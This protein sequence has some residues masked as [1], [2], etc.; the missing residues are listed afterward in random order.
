MENDSTDYQACLQQYFISCQQYAK[1]E[2]E[3]AILKL[4]PNIT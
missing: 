2:A 4:H 1:E 3:Q